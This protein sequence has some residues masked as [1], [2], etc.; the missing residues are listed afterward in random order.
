MKVPDPNPGRI[1]WENF[2]THEIMTKSG[3]EKLISML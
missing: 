2:F 3:F 1:R